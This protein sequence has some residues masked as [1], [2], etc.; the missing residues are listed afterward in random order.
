MYGIPIEPLERATRNMEQIADLTDATPA[1]VTKSAETHEQVL[2]GVEGYRALLDCLTAEHFGAKGASQL[3]SEGSDLD[4]ERWS[5]TVESLPNREQSWVKKATEASRERRFFHWDIGFPDVFFTH[6]GDHNGRRFDAIVGNP[7][8]DVLSSVEI[9]TDVEAEKLYYRGRKRFASGAGRSLNV[10]R[11]FICQS[12]Q[13]LGQRRRL[14]FIIPLGLLADE[15]GRDLRKHLLRSHHLELV[16]AFPQKDDPKRRVFEEAKLSTCVFALSCEAQDGNRRIVYQRVAPQD[17]YR[18]LIGTLVRSGSYC[19]DTVHYVPQV[20]CSISQWTLLSL[21]NSS[22]E[23]WFFPLLSSNNDISKYKADALP[24]PVFHYQ[25]APTATNAADA[26][27]RRVVAA[28]EHH[29]EKLRRSTVARPLDN[30]RRFSEWADQCDTSKPAPDEVHDFLGVLALRMD[31]LCQSTESDVNGLADALGELLDCSDLDRW[32]GISKLPDIDYMG[33]DARFPEWRPDDAA[34]ADGYWFP[35]GVAPPIDGTGPGET[36]FDLIAC[37]YPSYSLPG[38]DHDTWEAGAWE[39]LCDLL[40]KNKSKIGSDRIRADLT[41]RGVITHPTGPM[42]KLQ[43]TFFKYHRDIR[44]N[45]AKA[46]EID[47]LIDRIVF[48]LFDLTLD[49]QKLILSRVGPGRPLPPRRGRRKK[50]ASK[51]KLDPTPTLFD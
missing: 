35:N 41:G 25:S 39:E 6:R 7:P 8:Y 38:I 34:V 32:T 36:P 44:E 1:E 31:E 20:L 49:E 43:E 51:E 16:D 2:A 29:I 10:W 12:V 40:R 37:V 21:W 9:G 22:F 33:W 15:S 3:V 28:R 26:S 18:R 45:R 46:A 23:E 11:L 47:F 48:R 14:G 50:S 13:L 24:A 30:E 17:N 5:K 19:A 4:L 27:T 42:G